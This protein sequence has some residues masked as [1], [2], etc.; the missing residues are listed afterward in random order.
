VPAAEPAP[1]YRNPWQAPPAQRPMAQPAQRPAHQQVP[2]PV[3][4]KAAQAADAWHRA[5]E[6]PPK[7]AA[8]PAQPSKGPQAA[9]Q[10]QNA[11]R[12]QTQNAQSARATQNA[13]AQGAQYRQNTQGSGKNTQ[14][15]GQNAQ[16]AGQSAQGQGKKKKKH[17]V[18]RFFSVL[19][20]IVLL[21]GGGAFTLLFLAA[22]KV[23]YR[24][25]PQADAQAVA[26]VP[27][28]AL[29]TNILLLGVD[30]KFSAGARTDTMLL[31]SI[32]RSH[33]KLKLTSFL[34]DTLVR[35]PG[36]GQDRLNTAYG[37]GGAPAT[38]R[39]IAE[40]FNL[41]VDHYVLL[42]YTTFENVIDA[43]GGADVPIEEKE[44]EFLCRTT[45]LGRQIGRE[46]MRAQ[47]AQNGA[48]HL[49]GVQALIYCRIRKLD[50][51]LH[52]AQRQRRLLESVM[53]KCKADP[54]LWLK[55]AQSVLP[56]IETDMN[57]L[58]LATLAMGAPLCLGYA[59]AQHQVPASGTWV[60][61]T[62]NG[63]SVIKLKEDCVELNR[64]QLKNFVEQS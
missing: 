17:R 59:V 2:R 31:L 18:R 11:Q 12:P 33:R 20:V 15:A 44:I 37:Q 22:G 54:R 58:T 14:A 46:S 42:N 52:R 30:G 16:A 32:D 23:D 43:L 61:A 55:L 64:Q 4:G 38:M 39:A 34:R 48:V 3:Q 29:I 45:R 51:D 47:M 26:A 49:N 9:R 27:S 8:R 19:L 53:Q 50:D 63:A 56:E 62:V 57:Q 36:G 24:A 7:A 28:K 25:I 35:L 60:Y 41:R 21:L 5:Q 10:T 1:G 40:N 6:N 13:Q